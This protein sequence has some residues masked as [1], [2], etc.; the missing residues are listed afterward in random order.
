MLPD[1]GRAGSFVAQDR[2][3]GVAWLATKA[4]FKGLRAEHGGD[5]NFS[6]TNFK[7]RRIIV[8]AAKAGKSLDEARQMAK[9]Y[10]D[11]KFADLG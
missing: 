5:P 11:R 1:Y 7:L 9:E 10:A 6:W 3:G 2:L 8:R 4:K